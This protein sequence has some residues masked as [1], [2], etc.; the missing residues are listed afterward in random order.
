MSWATAVSVVSV[1][2]TVPLLAAAFAPFDT[3]TVYCALCW[4]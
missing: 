2:M 4:P 1:T 3:V